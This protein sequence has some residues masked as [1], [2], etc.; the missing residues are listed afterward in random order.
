MPHWL[1][2]PWPEYAS[3][4]FQQSLPLREDGPVLAQ[5]VEEEGET[6]VVPGMQRGSQLAFQKRTERAGIHGFHKHASLIGT[7]GNEAQLVVVKAAAQRQGFV[8]SGRGC[9]GHGLSLSRRRGVG[10]VVEVQHVLNGIVVQCMRRGEPHEEVFS[11]AKEIS[12]DSEVLAVFVHTCRVTAVG[13]V[14]AVQEIHRKQ[15]VPLASFQDIDMVQR[16][17]LFQEAV[18][19]T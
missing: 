1:A 15:L 13:V 3:G 5:L 9:S 4:I 17:Q 16:K 8:M 12:Q 7:I 10:R 19:I 11:G 6:A 2:I 18:Q 14:M